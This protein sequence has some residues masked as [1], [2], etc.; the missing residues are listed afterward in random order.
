MTDKRVRILIDEHAYLDGLKQTY[1]TEFQEVVDYVLPDRSN[2]T[3]WESP[4]Q[5]RGIMRYDTTA[6]EAA[7]LLA[8]N[9]AATLTPMGSRWM[10]VVPRQPELRRK[11]AVADWCQE[12][13][14]LMLASTQTSNFY[15]AMDEVYLDLVGFATACPY[16]ETLGGK[17]HY[18]A[19][20]VREY[21]FSVGM[22][23]RPRRLFRSFKMTA[24]QM[25]DRFSNMP[26]FKEYGQSVKHIIDA[27]ENVSA[28]DRNREFR[29]LHVIGP[30]DFYRPGKPGAKNMP[31]E[32]CYINCDDQVI[33]AEGG[34]EEM[35]AN[36]VRWRVTA[37]DA[38]W[39]R[40]PTQ[41]AMPDVRS[42]NVCRKLM[43]KALAKDL[44]PPLVIDDRGVIGNVRTVPNGI[45]YIR[46][47]A[48]MEYLTS[49]QRIDIGQFG[50]ERL[51][52]QVRAIYYA[53]HL[54]LPPPQGTPMT[55]TEMQ[56]RW[57]MMERLLGPTL[58]RLQT[59]LLNPIIERTFGLMMRAGQLPLPPDEL[60]DAELDIEYVGPLARAQQMPEVAAI[61]RTYQSV[62]GIAQLTGDTA[63]LRRLNVDEAT[64]RL[65]ELYGFPAGALRDDDEVQQMAQAEA[66]R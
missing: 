48:R 66:Q 55:A 52:Q 12:V 15:L 34:Y 64:K 63:G 27:A 9:L 32:S 57:E 53:D 26:G 36:V 60:V 1:A 18:M 58:G 8:G 20:P 24:Q 3:R 37:D 49:G 62:A 59:E 16:T 35:P 50:L 21:V 41:T 19:W 29:I 4:G 56:I 47:G 42:L 40:G 65:A 7:E 22:D 46:P 11:R 28:T 38:G 13:S 45:T 30:R 54:R 39:G 2:V 43:H 17:L 61:E 6:V 23:S 33:I 5:R 31:I 51:T 44:D 25:V 10:D 14:E